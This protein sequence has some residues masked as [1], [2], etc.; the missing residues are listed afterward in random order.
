MVGNARL[1]YQGLPRLTNFLVMTGFVASLAW[2]GPRRASYALRVGA[3]GMLVVQAI[4]FLPITGE[5]RYFVPLIPLLISVAADFYERALADRG[6]SAGTRWA[7]YAAMCLLIV[8]PLVPNYTGRTGRW[9]YDIV[10]R[11]LAAPLAACPDAVVVTDAAWPVTWYFDRTTVVIPLTYA[12]L[13]R[14]ERKLD[15]PV[16]V[17]FF[18]AGEQDKYGRSVQYEQEY[19]DNPEFNRLHRLAIGYESGAR[20]Y[21]YA[22]AGSLP[23]CDEV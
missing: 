18:Y 12:D 9:D 14:I 21:V 7:L 20:L 6:V 15:T 11:D 19:F 3:L 2:P 22:P 8:G 10:R 5:S 17:L 16:V 1:L 4:V 23:M 13:E